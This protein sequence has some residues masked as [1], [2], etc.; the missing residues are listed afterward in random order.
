M[1]P[2]APPTLDP[3]P[4]DPLLLKQIALLRDFPDAALTGLAGSA[5]ERKL[6]RREVVLNKGYQLQFFPFLLDGR[7]QGIDFTLDGREVGLY[8]VG[9]G[10]F[11]GELSVIDRQ[12]MAETVIALSPS[13]LVLFPKEQARAL[14]FSTPE[15]SEKVALRLAARLRAV[16]SQRLLLALPNPMQ[17]LCAQLLQLGRDAATDNAPVDNLL[18]IPAAPTHQEIAIMINLSRETVTRAFQQLQNQ[19]ILRRDGAQLLILKADALETLSFG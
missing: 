12:P 8:F 13:R 2:R 14:M 19:E 6:V 11:F 4:I 16:G 15:V 1:Q 10:E 17:R 5:I 7:L 18:T 9:P 3:M